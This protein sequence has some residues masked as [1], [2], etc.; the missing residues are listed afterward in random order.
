MNISTSTTIELA[1][2]ERELRVI[3]LCMDLGRNLVEVTNRG[4][5]Y[6]ESCRIH[7]NLSE[8]YNNLLK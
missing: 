4:E 6:Q 1:L 3:C 8:L 2:S 7:H 5:D